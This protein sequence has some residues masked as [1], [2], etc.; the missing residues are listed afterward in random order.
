MREIFKYKLII[1]NG[2]SKI[3]NN[4]NANSGVP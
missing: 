1:R 2:T 3:T 4:S